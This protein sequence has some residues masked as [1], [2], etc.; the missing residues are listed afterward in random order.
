MKKKMQNLL[1]K[2]LNSWCSNPEKYSNT[3][4]NYIETYC[5]TLEEVH[6][7][8]R[9]E[10][11]KNRQKFSKNFKKVLVLSKKSQNLSY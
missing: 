4:R 1:K 8:L 3:M 7:L 6:R 5:Q 9:L 11:P 10:K 2:C